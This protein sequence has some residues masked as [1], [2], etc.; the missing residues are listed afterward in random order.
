MRVPS[1]PGAA[2]VH[3]IRR[4][5]AAILAVIVFLI[6]FV[7]AAQATA[8]FYTNYLWYRS[9]GLTMVWRSMIATKLELGAV[10]SG[11]M[12]VATWLSLFVVDRIAPRALFMSP[13]LELVRRYQSSIGRYRVTVRSVVAVLVGL[14]VGAG[15]TGQWQHWLLFVHGGSFGMKDPQFH[16]DVG[17]F[18]FQLPFLSFLVDWAQLA[19][20]VLFVVSVVAHYLNGGVRFSG[21][22]PRV[23]ARA[24]AHLSAIVAG[25][26]LL[27]AVAYFTIDRYALDLS[28][29]GV[30]TGAGYTD[31]HVR[32]PALE[33]L[34]LVALV[35]FGLL[36]VNIYQRSLLLPAVGVGLWALLAI[37]VGV[38]FPAAVQWLQVTPAQSSAELPYIARNIAA[39][40]AAMGL[41]DIA[42]Q[43]FNANQDLTG[44]VIDAP[45]N[46]PT[47]ESVSY[48]DPGVAADTYQKLQNV[49]G[50]YNVAGLSSDRYLLGTGSHRRLTPVVIGVRQVVP[51][52]VGSASWVNVHLEYTHGYGY[53]MSPANS[54]VQNGEPS[55]VA[56][57]VPPTESPGAP[58]LS[59]KSLD[60]YFGTGMSGYA[61]VD[62]KQ[63][64]LDYIKGPGV[65]A[66]SHYQGTGGIPLGGFWTRAAF[67]LRF[68]DFNLLVSRLITPRSRIMYFQDIRTRVQHAAPFLRVD[69]HPY[70]VVADGQLWWMVDA[71]TTTSYYPYGQI[72]DTSALPAGSGLGG[73]YNY[74]RD[75]VKVVVN[76][77]S[78]ALSFYAVDPKDPILQAWELAFPGM[79]QP[80]SKMLP[81]LRQHLRYPQDLLMVQ[82]AM[83]GRYH[84]SPSDASA[85]YANS[86][87]WTIAPQSFKT[88][89]PIRPIYE[90]LRM[91]R[92]SSLSFVALEPLVP[93]SLNGRAQRMS[94]FLVA[95]CAGDN[96]GQLTSYEVQQGTSPVYSPAYVFGS[97]N[98][99][100]AVSILVTKLD[101][102]GS[103]VSWGPTIMLPIDDSVL[104]I[105]TLYLRSTV[106]P[107]PLVKDVIVSY[108]DG[109]YL[110]PQL[111][112]PKGALTQVFGQ[113]V[114]SIGSSGKESIDKTV[115]LLLADA[116]REYA[117]A[118]RAI[119][120]GDY[121]AWGQDLSKVGQDLSAAQHEL[122][123]ASSGGGSGSGSRPGSLSSSG[124]GSS[125]SGS[126]PAGGRSTS[127]PSSS[128]AA[129]GSPTTTTLAP[130][131][132][133]VADGPVAD[134]SVADGSVA[135]GSVG[136]GPSS[137]KAPA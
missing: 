53:V 122:A 85:F 94:A 17:Y 78:G 136:R 84:V 50:Y 65:A 111:L 9:V 74:V 34:A 48:W 100:Q 26:A 108:R 25:F 35:A 137:T 95:S 40:R 120:A 72:V 3:S 64:E 121:L 54:W 118:Q 77:Y 107:A 105:V 114:G 47:V 60:V 83:F 46:Q 127:T 33:L 71:Y 125:G 128:A 98:Q 63:P 93:M 82:S 32:L 68:H 89:L 44:A 96:Y 57:S 124:A 87:A 104:F 13:E 8:N 31:I 52:Q 38:I 135:D 126:L 116:A 45:N 69:A 18:V 41:D 115:R 131:D 39:T 29:S 51:T 15:A 1:A 21:P 55:F 11:L 10:F 88:E 14:A 12:L 6:L 27:R 110:A 109:V 4:Y 22:S 76:A 59:G 70:P 117:A 91:P 16:R 28:N 30:V 67:A 81:A 62:T 90:L 42:A 20:I 79:F 5:Q 123:L 132:G 24:V 66:T 86:D 7:V 92:Q 129:A 19:L 43:S 49:R 61:V 134:G 56:A 97:I 58:Q 113:S 130:F 102:H 37:V 103:S 112:G 133:P 106:N 80:M 101:Q 23:D 119:R 75:S 2:P 36:V 73:S 99:N